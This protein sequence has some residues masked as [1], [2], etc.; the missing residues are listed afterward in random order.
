MLES[1][2][3]G[4]GRPTLTE[5]AVRNRAGGGEGIQAWPF[6]VFLEPRGQVLGNAQCTPLAVGLAGGATVSSWEH[7][8]EWCHRSAS[9]I[10]LW[11]RARFL[12]I[13]RAHMP[14]SS[15]LSPQ[16]V[17][18]ALHPGRGQKA[19]RWLQTHL[20]CPP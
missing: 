5:K 7:L 10:L 14:T 15:S 1:S 11:R 3:L 20:G 17:S 18:L 13:M 16:L 9:S 2:G 4:G 19:L 6:R 12:R 8:R